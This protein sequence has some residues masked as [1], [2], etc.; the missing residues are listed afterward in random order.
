MHARTH[1]HSH[2]GRFEGVYEQHVHT[3]HQLSLQERQLVLAEKAKDKKKEL[4]QVADVHVQLQNCYS[5]C[6]LRQSS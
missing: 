5:V 6:S 2:S 4:Q 1:R 3:G